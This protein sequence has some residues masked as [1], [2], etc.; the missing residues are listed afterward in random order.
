MK[1]KRIGVAAI[2][3]AAA[4]ALVL[5]GCTSGSPE[6]TD[7][8]STSAV[9]TTNGSEPQNPL[10]PTNTNE[11]GGGKIIDS[12]F[13]G[14]VYYDADGAVHNDVA[15]SIDTEDAQN[16]TIKIR[17]GLKFTNGEDVT[18]SSFVDAWN[19][20]ANTAN[21]PQLS[22]Y[23]FADIEGFSYDEAVEELPGL[24]VVDDTTFTVA[25]IQPE[26]DFPLSL[27]YSAFYPLPASAFDDIDAFG[28]NPIGNG[29][30]MLDGEG[31]WK[32]N[33]RIS[34]VA[35]PDYDGPRTPKN[36]GLDIVFYATQEAA[37]ADLQG[38]NLDVL[39]AIPDGAL[40]TFQDEFGDRSVTQA[41]AIFQSFTVPSRLA[42]F[43][44]EEG[45]LR[46]AAISKAIDRAEITDVIFSGTRTPAHDFTSPVIDGYSEDI[47]GSDVLD[48]DA[49]AAKDLWAQA[50]AISPWSG[51]FQIAYNA[52][53]G[54]QAWVDAVANQLKNNL[55]I[56]A[57]GAPYPT[58][59]EVRTAITDRTI[60]TAFRTGWQADYPALFNFLGPIY[61]TGAGSND[62]DYSNADFDALL[63]EGRA[64]T[65]LASANEK[66]QQAQEILFKDLPAIPL[67]YS[68]VNGA[69][70]QNV[71]SVQFGWNSVPLYYEI[72]KSE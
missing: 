38:G 45:N 6:A 14:L 29:P 21:G 27:G 22:Q 67:W 31:A 9:V 39:D 69:W 12:I 47:P 61:A 35:N 3:L 40:S 57:S 68:T 60:E 52:D 46:R 58:F 64:D 8:A 23:F 2:A 48:F 59:A 18:A 63:K 56:D 13:A 50:D 5:T 51:T 16:Y 36:G 10:V 19:Y 34:L 1:I 53:G 62:G 11:T 70:S 49:D 65:D 30:Y 41:A 17:E 15:E 28:E 33:E 44:G 7:G 55:G 26:S 20:G 25:L 37:Y 43:G 72:T 54:H 24:K 32:H 42:H 71:E 66:F 4:G